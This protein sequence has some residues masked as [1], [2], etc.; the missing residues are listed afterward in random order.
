M[1]SRTEMGEFYPPMKNTTLPPILGL[2]KAPMP[3][4][5]HALA[6]AVVN[7]KVYVIADG[8][9][10]RNIDHTNEEYDPATQHHGPPKQLCPQQDV[11]LAAAAVNNKVYAIRGKNGRTFTNEEY[12][13]ATNTWT[14]K[15]TMPTARTCVSRCGGCGALNTISI[16]CRKMSTRRSSFPNLLRDNSLKKQSLCPFVKK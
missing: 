10:C 8:L 4:A 1:S 15:D 2:P 9:E 13:P 7:N 16:L 3:T 11:G 12:D 14:I 5:R 6:A